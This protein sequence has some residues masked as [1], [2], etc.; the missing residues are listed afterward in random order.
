M[1]TQLYTF[2][3]GSYVAAEEWNANFKVL[4][5][6]N[7]AHEESLSD[8]YDELAFPDSDF[9][10]IVVRAK[11]FQN[12]WLITGNTVTV[13][14]GQEYYKVLSSAQDLTINIP[15]SG[16]NAEARVLIQLKENRSLLPFS[17][18][19]S[20]GTVTINHY[21]NYVFRPGYYYIMIYET[22]KVAQVKLIW[23]GA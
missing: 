16:L 23:T 18:N 14:A 9:S 3:P 2:S 12:S 11:A 20:G 10:Q 1:I 7:L 6:T 17:V 13:A 4:Y 5:N 22:N 8:A 21:N 15:S 19:Y